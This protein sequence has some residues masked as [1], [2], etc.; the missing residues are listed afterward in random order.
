MREAAEFIASELPFL[1]FYFSTH[2]TGARTGVR[3]LDDVAGGM[4]SSRPYG[5]YSRNAHLWDVD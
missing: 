4:Q 5:T 3:A 1:I 2:H